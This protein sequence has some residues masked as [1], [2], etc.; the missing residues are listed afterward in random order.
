MTTTYKAGERPRIEVRMSDIWRPAV[1]TKMNSKTAYFRMPWVVGEMAVEVNQVSMITHED[2]T[3]VLESEQWP[4]LTPY[5]TGARA[6]PKV[7]TH[8]THPQNADEFDRFG[9][10]DF[11]DDTS[12]TIATVWIEKRDG[13]H[14]LCIDDH[15]ET[16]VIDGQARDITP[17]D[18]VEAID[19]DLDA[20]QVVAVGIDWLTLDI[21]GMETIRLPLD[22]YRVVQKWAPG[23]RINPRH[24]RVALRSHEQVG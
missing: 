21:H 5:D 16:L 6:E 19:R 10:V 13:V 9:K 22:N 4:P 11:D 8:A 1:L 20:R 18:W 3:P 23:E 14:T 12:T 24:M 15:S 7:W 2:G 17:G